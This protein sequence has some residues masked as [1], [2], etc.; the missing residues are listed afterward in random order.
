LTVP[1]RDAVVHAQV[2]TKERRQARTNAGQDTPPPHDPTPQANGKIKLVV[3]GQ[4]IEVDADQ[5]LATAQKARAADSYLAEARAM[6]DEAKRER[7]AAQLLKTEAEL[8]RNV[9]GSQDTDKLYNDAYE[10]IA[11]EVD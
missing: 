10:S 6:L 5:L 9:E 2:G 3:R 11:Y 1:A 4:A 8:R 7:V